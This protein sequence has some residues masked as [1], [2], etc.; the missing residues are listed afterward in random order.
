MANLFKLSWRIWLLII[1]LILSVISISPNPF[2]SGVLIK[3]VAANSTESKIGMG[4]GEIILSIN[5]KEVKNLEDYSDIISSIKNESVIFIKTNKNEYSFLSNG[6]LSLAVSEVPKSNLKA[7]LDLVGGSRALVRPEIEVSDKDMENLISIMEN[8]FNVYGIS[9]I[10]IKGV[11]DLDGNKFVL[12]EA[13]GVSVDELKQLISQQGKFEAKIGNETVFVGG[14][15]D[16]TS[17]CR[18][19]PSCAGITGCFS[20]GN[21]QVC[22][23]QFTVYL[24]EAAAKRH[25]SITSNLS[26]NLSSPGYLNKQLDLYIDDKLVDSLLI[27]ENLKG[28]VTT[29]ISVSGSGF[30]TTRDEAIENAQLNMKRLQTILITGSL[31]F[32]VKIEKLD[33]ISSG[34]G[35]QLS[36]NIL[37]TALIAFLAVSLFVYIRYRNLKIVMPIILTMLGEVIII[38]GIA[39]LIKW[40]LDLPSIAGILVVIGT[41][42]DHQ[43]IILDEIKLGRIYGW[44]ER[45]KR[46]FFIILGA[47]ATTFVAMLPLAWAGAG[48][49]KGFAITTIIGISAGVFITRPAF[50][51][52]V[53]G[54][55]RD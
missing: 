15:R 40:N 50:S 25:A 10:R 17:V 51:D 32:K 45:I 38:L 21:Q 2:K 27:S 34:I 24:S 49:L 30:G 36:R 37:I 48:L 46:A 43:I 6:T 20:S 14:E 44:K 52:M 16:I 53:R 11:K 54:I 23:F 42:L 28:V 35:E 1:V 4:S 47:F 8:R 5:G 3:S 9:D 41:G 26:V 39:S 18:F 55:V 29:K 22:R 13:A 12:I 31:P 33:S 7:G 19:D